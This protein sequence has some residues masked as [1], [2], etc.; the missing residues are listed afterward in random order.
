[1]VGIER[2]Y[3]F[4]GVLVLDSALHIGGGDDLASVTDAAVVRTPAGTPYIPG[5]SFKGAFRSTVEKIAGAVGGIRTCCLDPDDDFC[6][7][8]VGGGRQLAF[9]RDEERPK[10]DRQF[11]KMVTARLCDTC[12]LFGS[13]YLASRIAFSDLYL[14]S[15]ESAYTQVRDGVGIDRDSERAVD[16]IKYDYETVAPGA[17]F[18]AEIMLLNPSRKDLFLTCIGLQEYLSG[19]GSLGGMRSRGL[20]RCRLADLSVYEL[21]LSDENRCIENL[22]NYL[23]ETEPEKKMRRIGPAAAFIKEQILGYL[24]GEGSDAQT[25]G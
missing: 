6:I 17:G 16:N 25:V 11:V 23:L 12:I 19:F 22:R 24:E 21:D 20:G 1:L 18:E 9:S 2:R 15:G 7:G 8:P 10:S 5:S 4:K 14:V 3:L 13:P